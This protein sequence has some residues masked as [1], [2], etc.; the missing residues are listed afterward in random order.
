M[1]SLTAVASLAARAKTA[2]DHLDTKENEIDPLK[3][4]VGPVVDRISHINA[5]R[6]M[7]KKDSR[8]AGCDHYAGYKQ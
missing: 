7:A 4:V 3:V 5:R 1:A 2:N 6:A 8:K